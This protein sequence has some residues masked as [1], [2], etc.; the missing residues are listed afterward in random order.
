MSNKAQTKL[1]Y[2]NIPLKNSVRSKKE[3]ILLNKWKP[4][5]SRWR[6][7]RVAFYQGKFAWM[8]QIS[9]SKTWSDQIEVKAA[10]NFPVRSLLSSSELKHSCIFSHIMY[11]KLT[12]SARNI[13]RKLRL[14]S[15]AGCTLFYL[16]FAGELTRGLM[17]LLPANARFFAHNSGCFSLQFPILLPAVTVCFAC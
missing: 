12:A 1:K 17:A 8:F 2:V 14:T 13:A 16:K 5:D 6:E 7:E 15:N 4:L 9:I 10:E 3:D 11:A